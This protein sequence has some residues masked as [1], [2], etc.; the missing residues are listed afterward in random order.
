MI[1]KSKDKKDEIEGN[2][3]ACYLLGFSLQQKFNEVK[4]VQVN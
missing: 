2:I 1:G 3:K 4:S